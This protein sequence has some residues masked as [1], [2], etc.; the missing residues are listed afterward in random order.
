MSSSKSRNNPEELTMR[1]LMILLFL[2]TQLLINVI[3]ARAQDSQPSDQ[4]RKTQIENRFTDVARYREEQRYE[5]C[6]DSLDAVIKLANIRNDFN[7]RNET[8]LYRATNEVV[9][10]R[11]L[12]SKQV[13]AQVQTVTDL[14]SR[15]RAT[16]DYRF[17]EV[18]DTIERS[19]QPDQSRDI[20]TISANMDA[21]RGYLREHA[22]ARD[23]V[24]TLAGVKRNCESVTRLAGQ[25]CGSRS[26][27]AVGSALNDIE[28]DRRQA[29]AIEQRA[30]R[31]QDERFGRPP[32]SPVSGDQMIRLENRLGAFMASTAYLESRIAEHEKN[33]GQT[34][35]D[36]ERNLAALGLQTERLDLEQ[37]KF[38]TL[39][40]AYRRCGEIV[41]FGEDLTSSW[42][43]SVPSDGPQAARDKVANLDKLLRRLQQWDGA[44]ARSSAEQTRAN[45]ER[46]VAQNNEVKKILTDTDAAAQAVRD[47]VIEIGRDRDRART[48]FDSINRRA[49]SPEPSTSAKPTP[50]PAVAPDVAVTPQKADSAGAVARQVP[51]P[52]SKPPAQ[53]PV[54]TAQVIPAT[55]P[56]EPNVAGGIKIQ[57]PTTR[58][59]VGQRVRFIA[60]DYG[61]RP[62][63]KVTWTSFDEELLSLDS[64]GWATGLNPGALLIHAKLDDERSATLAVEVVERSNTAT[65]PAQSAAPAATPAPAPSSGFQVGATQAGPASQ[66]IDNSSSAQTSPAVT[67]APDNNLTD[68][69]LLGIDVQSAPEPAAGTQGFGVGAT[70]AGPN[71]SQEPSPGGGSGPPP[72]GGGSPGGSGGQNQQRGPQQPRPQRTR[73]V[74]GQPAAYH[75]F[76]AGSRLG[77]ASGLGQYS[78]GPADSTIIEHL[79]V[80]GEHVMWANRESYL[81]VKAW[82]N[83]TS[84]RAEIRSWADGLARNPDNA[85]RRQIP[86]RANSLAGT[87][88][89]QLRT[90]TM[91]TPENVA[92]CDAAY[93]NLG[94]EL[95][96]AQQTLG[97]A[98]EA[99]QNGDAA[100]A[101]QAQRDGLSHLQTSNRILSDYERTQHLTGRCADLRDVRT[102]IDAIIRSDARDMTRQSA[103][104]TAAWTLALERIVALRGGQQI[105]TT[106]TPPATTT[107][108]AGQPAAYHIFAAG[109]RLGWAS[110]LGQYSIGPADRSIIEHLQVAGEHV[111][112]ANR[113]SYLPVKAWPNCT[114]NRAE[115]RSWADDLSRKPDNATRRQIPIRANSLAGTLANQLRTQ[116]MGTPEQVATCDAA[117]MNLGYQL[118]YA[119]QALAIAV[120]AAQNGDVALA[121]QAQRDGMSHLQN[122]SR[123]LFDYER[124]ISLTGRCADLRDVRTQ[125]DAIIRS[126]ARDMAHQSTATAAAWRLALERI[127]ALRGGQQTQTPQTPPT[128]PSAGGRPPAPVPA[129]ATGPDPGELEGYWVSN[130]RLYR[131]VKQGD[132]YI[133]S[134]EQAE[135]DAA[136][137]EIRT[138]D[139]VYRLK[140]LGPNLYKGTYRLRRERDWSAATYTERACDRQEPAWVSVLGIG[141]FFW[142]PGASTAYLSPPFHL[143]PPRDQAEASVLGGILVRVQNPGTW[144]L[145]NGRRVRGFGSGDTS[146]AYDLINWMPMGGSYL[147]KPLWFLASGKNSD[148]KPVFI[149][150]PDYDRAVASGMNVRS[151]PG[152]WGPTRPEDYRIDSLSRDYLTRG[153]FSVIFGPAKIGDICNELVKYPQDVTGV[154]R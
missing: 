114:A 101:Q 53:A 147:D 33:R 34:I 98:F 25:V 39:L 17:W 125:I 37:Q 116:T 91:G 124:I 14:A 3:P 59:F 24:A 77:W 149:V 129:Q 103:A 151:F 26:R 63:A 47:A 11:S 131:F 88:A 56:V 64:Q 36:I 135:S 133:G 111:I 146:N 81:P 68:M 57:G 84:N 109:S 40:S 20:A 141:A 95:G 73:A 137:F 35:L 80:S 45:L 138:G 28:V 61:N 12:I 21:T 86:I 75:I 13:Q 6:L 128:P 74:A 152:A 119:Q 30:E 153:G 148:G 93:M 69:N 139:L 51:T 5:L 143:K 117:Y 67:T 120:E 62:Y 29:L 22:F 4:E 85:T 126:D 96:Y 42:R 31:W 76:A 70:T 132:E 134:L 142:G 145:P 150:F 107:P 52:Q 79:Q 43:R 10:I 48:C 100:L 144:T 140:R 121:Q 122:S 136:K 115:I 99:A 54:P 66:S 94:Y 60:T 46:L 27:D 105:Q 92:T 38:E 97:I 90:Q 8:A 123:I 78:I 15:I 113:E 55:P 50:S 23:H 106:Q 44:K 83:W 89:N 2:A 104:T 49:T 1:R 71:D 127:A 41:K 7:Q 16:T 58:I 82:P 18:A 102:Q 130:Q 9:A 65:G 87:L 154:Q 118:G 32:D 110:G 72:Q 112:W 19:E 108:V